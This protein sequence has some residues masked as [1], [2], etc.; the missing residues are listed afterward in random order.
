MVSLQ[1]YLFVFAE[2]DDFWNK[3]AEQIACMEN[4]PNSEK[5]A[6]QT[7]DVVGDAVVALTRYEVPDIPEQLPVSIKTQSEPLSEKSNGFA[8]CDDDIFLNIGF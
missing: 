6:C 5:V 1:F 2:V 3:V 4:V 7:D 8:D